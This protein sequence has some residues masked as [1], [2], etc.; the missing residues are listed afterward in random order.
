M[1]LCPSP[2]DEE[3][4]TPGS[5]AGPSQSP[6][7][8]Q[9]PPRLLPCSEPCVGMKLV[10]GMGQGRGSRNGKPQRRAAH[11][12]RAQVCVSKVPYMSWSAAPTVVAG[13]CRHRHRR[14]LGPEQQQLPCAR[15]DAAGLTRPVLSGCAGLSLHL[16]PLMAASGEA[17]AH[18]TEQRDPGTMPFLYHPLAGRRAVP[19]ATLSFRVP[20]RAAQPLH[21]VLQLWTTF[22]VNSNLKPTQ[23]FGCHFVFKVFSFKMDVTAE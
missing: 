17:D 10:P 14:A 20:G 4:V 13:P 8:G 12:N 21:Q 9:K 11:G 16:W 18:V 19:Q 6:P 15:W 23:G 3:G 2:K 5:G 1:V 7:P 22:L